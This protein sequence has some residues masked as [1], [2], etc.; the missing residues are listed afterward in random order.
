MKLSDPAQFND[1]S[2]G[3]KDWNNLGRE[4]RCCRHPRILTPQGQSNPSVPKGIEFTRSDR[5]SHYDAKS[6]C[7][8]IAMRRRFG[9]EPDRRAYQRGIGARDEVS[10]K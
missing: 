8:D 4:R 5:W 1:K 6:P 3:A 2:I 9:D 7:Y 10:T